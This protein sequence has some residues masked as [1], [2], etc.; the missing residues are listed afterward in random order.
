MGCGLGQGSGLGYKLSLTG[1]DVRAGLGSVGMVGKGE[2]A[3]GTEK[4]IYFE[5]ME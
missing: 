1:L 4:I 2:G 3:P 5:L